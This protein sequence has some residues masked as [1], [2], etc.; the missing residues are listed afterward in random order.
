MKI[1]LNIVCNQSRTEIVSGREFVVLN[2]MAVRGDT[3]MNGKLYPTSVVT[4]K[5]ASLIGRPAP[6]SHPERDGMKVSANDFYSRGAFDIGAEVRDSRM[7]GNENV[8]EIWVD[9]E[10]AERSPKGQRLLEMVANQESIGVSTGLFPKSTRKEAGTDDL[11]ANYNEVVEDFEYDHLAILLNEKAA[12]AHAGTK[13][14]YNSETGDSFDLVTHDGQPSNPKENEMK[15]EFDISDLS[16]AQRVQFQA[17]TV[18]EIM[19]AVNQE[20]K[21]VTLEQAKEV[22][23]NSD[24]LVVNSKADGEFVSNE[25]AKLLAN[26][27]ADIEKRTKETI[28]SIVANSDFTTEMLQG[29]SEDELKILSGLVGNNK[30]DYSM[31]DTVTTNSSD[32]G[33]AKLTFHEDV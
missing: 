21:E 10:V 1:S 4:N 32:D 30:Q 3:A 27:K 12:G 8:T 28:D 17:L 13:I 6:V 5:A 19:E 24:E 18:N 23:A 22:I 33:E 25:D 29:K 20:P 26:A 16:K 31:R 11:G 9:K 7:V 15:H 14:I 2:A